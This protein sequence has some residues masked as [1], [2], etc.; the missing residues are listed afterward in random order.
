MPT[1]WE[2][3][4]EKRAPFRPSP[5]APQLLFLGKL[6]DVFPWMGKA[7]YPHAHGEGLCRSLG[8]TVHLIP[9]G[10]A[11]SSKEDCEENSC[12]PRHTPSH[13]CHG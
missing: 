4:R 2:K 9:P 10:A 13:S 3:G 11:A 12:L 1:E 7:G 6:S 8:H 5:Q